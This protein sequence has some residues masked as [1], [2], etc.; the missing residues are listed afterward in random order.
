MD[1]A[2]KK[3]IELYGKFDGV[4]KREISEGDRLNYEYGSEFTIS[5]GDEELKIG[6]LVIVE[7]NENW[8]QAESYEIK[9]NKLDGESISDELALEKLKIIERDSKIESIFN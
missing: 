6:Y 8:A 2:Y 1:K 3:I 5:I 7:D 9:W 4:K